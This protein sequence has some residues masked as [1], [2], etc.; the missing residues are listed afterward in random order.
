MAGPTQY[1]PPTN[2]QVAVGGAVQALN[3]ITQQ[4]NSQPIT[5]LSTSAAQALPLTPWGALPAQG[6]A[7][8]AV[9]NPN[10]YMPPIVYAQP[11]YK[12]TWL[13]AG[14]GA[15]LLLVGFTL[16]KLRPKRR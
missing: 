1:P 6:Q 13:M 3:T 4:L 9:I 5:A 7:P 11:F 16:F 12:N 8:L 14:V 15:G 2:Q 10:Q